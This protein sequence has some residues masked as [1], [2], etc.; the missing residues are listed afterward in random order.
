MG[1]VTGLA[2]LILLPSKEV[3]RKGDARGRE[4]QGAGSAIPSPHRHRRVKG[5]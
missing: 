2:Y 5:L 1:Q 4:W 3:D